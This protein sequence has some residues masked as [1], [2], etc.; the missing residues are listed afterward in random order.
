LAAPTGY[1]K[2]KS[3]KDCIVSTAV[4]AKRNHFAEGAQAAAAVEREI[5]QEID[6][7]EKVHPG[8]Q[9]KGAMQAGARRYPE[10]PFPKQHQVKP[11]TESD[12]DVEPMYD[13]PHYQG[14]EKLEGKV[15]LITGGDSGIG[16]AVA[17]L[18]ARE[19]AISRLF[20][21][22]SMKTPSKQKRLS[23]RKDTAALQS[24]VVLLIRTFVRKQ[25]NARQSSWGTPTFS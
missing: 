1:Q 16:R 2:N 9:E 4:N 15:A 3:R 11:G 23:R 21:L 10:P 17:V 12:L 8:E 6:R 7:E 22:R 24:R 18:F 5:Q 14:S 13:A 20:T 19:G 25:W